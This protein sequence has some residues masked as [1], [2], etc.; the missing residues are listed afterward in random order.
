MREITL[1]QGYAALIDAADYDEIAQFKWFAL[2][3]PH[4]VYA[5]RTVILPEGGRTSEYMH[6]RLLP[7]TKQVDHING[8]GLDNRR[9]NLRPATS[10]EN[11]RNR[12]G[13]RAGNTSGFRGVI[14]EKSRSKWR[15]QIKVDGRNRYLGR[16]DDPA[17]A[18][19][20]ANQDEP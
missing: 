12:S 18:A 3:T 10:A 16:F 7:S 19:R 20:F 2:V 15:A 9:S 13:L 11:V 17:E 14:W 5:M 4:T 6:R 1:S 8:N